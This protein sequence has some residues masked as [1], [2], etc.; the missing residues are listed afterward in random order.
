MLG[1]APYTAIIAD[2]H[3]IIRLAIRALMTRHGH[4][5]VA[6]TDN[7]I[8]TFQLARIHA[9]DIIILD[10]NTP[11]PHGLSALD[12]L[13]SLP[14]QAAILVFS[15]FVNDDY[16]IRCS[17]LG[18]AGFVSKQ[19]ELRELLSAINAILQGYSYFPGQLLKRL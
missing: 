11:H 15:D 10:L 16:A 18:A 9:P 19:A 13:Q 3:P 4:I 14:V 5:V 8:E 7:S 12:L 2:N 17:A 6:E 1:A